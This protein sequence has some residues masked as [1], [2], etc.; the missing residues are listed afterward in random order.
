MLLKGVLQKY[1]RRRPVGDYSPE[2][3]AYASERVMRKETRGRI[4]T[5]RAIKGNRKI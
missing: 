5:K 1:F 2:G 4:T 3:R